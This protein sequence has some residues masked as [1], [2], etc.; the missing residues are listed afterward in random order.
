MVSLLGGGGAEHL[1]VVHTARG[2]PDAAPDTALAIPPLLFPP[3]SVAPPL[4]TSAVSAQWGCELSPVA[5]ILGGMAGQ[6]VVKALTHK[7]E[8]I[9]NFFVF[10]GEELQGVIVTLPV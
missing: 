1:C 7:D 3:F 8:P 6:E 2:A 10:N 5:A 9:H 4:L